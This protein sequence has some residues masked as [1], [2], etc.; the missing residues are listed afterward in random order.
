MNKLK[1]AIADKI[2]ELSASDSSEIKVKLDKI[3]RFRDFI[4]AC[5]SLINKYPTIESEFMRMIE[6]NDFDARVASSRVD[7][8]I[9]LSDSENKQNKENNIQKDITEL[10]EI[11]EHLPVYK[12]API[13]ETNSITTDN[14]RHQFENERT[15][16]LE[17]KEEPIVKSLPIEEIDLEKEKQYVDFEE[18]TEDNIILESPSQDR[19]VREPNFKEN[20]SAKKDILKKVIQVCGIIAVIVALIFIIK[21]VINHWQLILWILGGCAVALIVVWYLLKKKKN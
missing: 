3:N 19:I 2:L 5:Q 11:T 16:E 7:F 10:E 6:N 15:P 12:D 4:D 14:Y 20:D 8:I 1:S 18:V 17:G 21:F 9:R 13:D